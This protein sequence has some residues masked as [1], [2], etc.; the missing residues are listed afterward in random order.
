MC[1]IAGFAD[2]AGRL[3]GEEMEAV[4]RSMARAMSHRG[5][6][7]EGVWIDG[8]RGITLAH[9]RLSI[10]D[11]SVE[12]RQP[13]TS[14]SQRFVAVFN[15][16]IYNYLQIRENLERA[17]LA[18]S[19][20]GHSDTEVFLA[21][22][23]AIGIEETLQRSNGMFAIVIWDKQEQVLVLVR[24]R[25]GEKPL[26]YGW[27]GTAFLFG[28]ELKALE[29]FPGFAGKINAHAV[30]SYLRFGYVPDPLSIYEGISKVRA[31]EIIRVGLHKADARERKTR[32]WSMPLPRPRENG[33]SKEAL[34]ELHSVLKEAVKS[35]MHADVPVGAFLSGGVDS[36]TVAALM[37]DVGGGCARTYSIGFEDRRHDEAVHAAVVA[38]ALGTTHEE[39][40]ISADDALR[41]VPDL[42]TL[43][44]EPFADSS[45]IPT[46]LLCKHTRRYVTVA[47]SGD[48]GD[49][50]FGGYVRY[51]QAERLRRVYGWIPKSLRRSLA[52]GMRHFGGSMWDKLCSGGPRSLGVA[53]SSERMGKLASVLEMNSVR[54]MYAGLV[55]HWLDP[56]LVGAEVPADC[57]LIDDERL[58][59]E[60]RDIRLWM[61]YLDSV[62]YLPGDILVK[63]DRAAMGASLETRIPF[64]DH[65]V[66]EFAATLP[67]SLKVRGV[68]GKWGLR[69]ILYK[70]LDQRLVERP[71]QGFAIPL[72]LWL[73]GPLRSWAED[74]LSER[75]LSLSGF[76][77]PAPIREAWLAHLSGKRN[78]RD[79][80]WVILMI[81]AWLQRGRA[82]IA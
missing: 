68:T 25:M 7:D 57:G 61:M 47:L 21:S 62:T 49:E 56:A 54:E 42:P 8:Q 15:G 24:D 5:P 52:G 20:R 29:K 67:L 46:F 18:P 6:D 36:S 77:D 82:G 22:C 23:D 58:F 16:E 39:I 43:Y 4:G 60:I 27:H 79:K 45:E 74:L 63:V 13:M 34:E 81:Q 55:S 80:L 50:L 40:Y 70:Y 17:G 64:L 35:R 30:S 75:A 71:K 73:R 19:W 11:L 48:A 41:V 31:G 3:S 14:A 33:D 12:G 65:R 59:S 69:Q 72:D 32:Y 44:D 76:L 51:V 78:S 1:G 38:K 10:V 66:V 26:Y 53:L 9:R 37:Q 28:S 2:L